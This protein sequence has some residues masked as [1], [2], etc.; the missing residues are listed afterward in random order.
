[1]PFE[2]YLDIDY[3]PQVNVQFWD[4]VIYDYYYRIR[5]RTCSSESILSLWWTTPKHCERNELNKR[6]KGWYVAELTSAFFTWRQ[7]FDYVHLAMFWMPP[8]SFKR[9]K[10][11]RISLSWSSPRHWFIESHACTQPFR[12]CWRTYFWFIL[13]QCSDLSSRFRG[14]SR[15]STIS[16]LMVLHRRKFWENL[17]CH[18]AL[19][20]PRYCKDV[21]TTKLMHLLNFYSSFAPAFSMPLLTTDHSESLTVGWVCY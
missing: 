20:G 10:P 7:T 1:M 2:T 11:F 17:C 4:D 13:G 12:P 3:Y 21:A 19:M 5:H 9:T 8:Q 16:F 14:K 6:Q 18:G 15:R